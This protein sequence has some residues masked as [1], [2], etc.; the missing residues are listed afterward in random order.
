MNT[1]CTEV[2]DGNGTH[3]TSYSSHKMS[4]VYVQCVW[5]AQN[6]AAACKGINDFHKSWLKLHE[7]HLLIVCIRQICKSN[8]SYTLFLF[9]YNYAVTLLG[10]V[11]LIHRLSELFH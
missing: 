10:I 7:V 8:T 2:M 5:T 11:Y 9:N 4:H 6:D 3:P 1:R